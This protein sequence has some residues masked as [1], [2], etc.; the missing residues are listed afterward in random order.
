MILRRLSRMMPACA[1]ELQAH[2]VRRRFA[3]TNQAMLIEPTLTGC[4][5]TAR[6]GAPLRSCQ[7]GVAKH[8]VSA[9]TEIYRSHLFFD[10]RSAEAPALDMSRPW[11]V[12]P[13]QIKIFVAG[14]L[15]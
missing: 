6:N 15:L 1:F 5:L 9:R 8:T 3:A 7:R 13:P 11:P 12:S 4:I 10:V 2:H 14:K